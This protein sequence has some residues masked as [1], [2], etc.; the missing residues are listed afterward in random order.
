[1]YK[2]DF[3]KHLDSKEKEGIISKNT[4]TNYYSVFTSLLVLFK[5]DNLKFILNAT[6]TLEILKTKYLNIGTLQTRISNIIYL[7][8]LYYSHIKTFKELLNTYEEFNNLLFKEIK[9]K[10]E[11]HSAT[12]RQQEKAVSKDENEL[13]INTLRKRVKN[14]INTI[15]DLRN[16]RNYIIY[17]FLDHHNFRGD[18]VKSKFV[19]YNDKNVYKEDMNYM[20]LDKINKKITYLQQNYKTKETYGSIEHTINNNLYKW[21]VKLYN[22]YHNKMKITKNKFLFYSN[23]AKKPY[24]VYNENLLSKLYTNIGESIIKKKISYQVS[25]IQATGEHRDA[26]EYLEDKSKGQQHSLATHSNI[27]YKKDLITKK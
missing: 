23:D 15:E 5:T 22:F 27:Y 3:K 11:T 13:I 1:M 10:Y 12:D 16:L 14:S 6:S 2:Q 4:K 9:K 21:F 17:I 18:F 8:K 7:L 25:R 24:T 19:L 26:I 20:I